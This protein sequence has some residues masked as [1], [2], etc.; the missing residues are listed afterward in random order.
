MSDDA[1]PRL[2]LGLTPLAERQV[3]EQLFR[4]DR[5]AVV[6]SAANGGELQTLAERR[7]PDAVLIGAELP[8]LD[9]AC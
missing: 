3:E 4:T 8:G 1:K 5:V 7:H 2:L 9:V 6:G